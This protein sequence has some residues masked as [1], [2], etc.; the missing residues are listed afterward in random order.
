[1]Y[2]Y[3]ALIRGI[4]V[5]G[6]KKVKMDLLTNIFQQLGHANVQTYIQ[7]GN[8][9][10]QNAEPDRHL[11]GEGVKRAILDTFGFEVSLLVLTRE[12]LLEILRK[13]PFQDL[14]KEEEGKRYFVLLMDVPDGE[15]VEAL[16]REDHGEESFV[17]SDHCIYLYC[18]KGYGQ[19]KYNNNYFERKLKIRATTRN[20]RTMQ[21]LLGITDQFNSQT[22]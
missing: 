12:D 15:R 14:D 10:F 7:S 1:M 8:I 4:N 13:D 5:S 11:L 3:I 17:V 6:Q 22:L 2:T 18:N 9:C 21:K 20:L 19:T 16:T